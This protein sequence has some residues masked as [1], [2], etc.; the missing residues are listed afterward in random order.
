MI[1]YNRGNLSLV[2]FL[3]LLSFGF[4]H[5]INSQLTFGQSEPPKFIQEQTQRNIEKYLELG[6]EG[7]KKDCID[8]GVPESLCESLTD[9]AKEDVEALQQNQSSTIDSQDNTYETYINNI[10][11][12][13]VEYPSDW[14]ELSGEIVK[15]TREFSLQLYNNSLFSLLDSDDFADITYEGYQENKDV[16]VEDELGEI[17]IDG[18]SAYTFSFTENNKKSMLVVL[19]HEN[20]GYLFK[21]ETLKENFEKDSD[22][23]WR[24]FSSVRFLDN[25]SK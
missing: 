22:I 23:M 19:M 13:S 25:N 7:F 12:Y 8:G 24:F 6:E 2:V 11:G 14:Q 17:N 20:V 9:I 5:T 21:Y 3:A 16:E 18:E 4:G 1:S 10:R 15:G